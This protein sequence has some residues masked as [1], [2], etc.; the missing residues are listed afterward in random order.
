MKS[1]DVVFAG[2]AREAPAGA[3]RPVLRACFGV[4]CVCRGHCARYAAVDDSQAN[5][6]TLVTCARGKSLP[7]FVK[8]MSA[9]RR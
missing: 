9:F 5:P 3:E 8:A 4:A 6:E 7:L 2:E 1:D